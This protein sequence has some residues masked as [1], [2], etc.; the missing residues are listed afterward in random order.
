MITGAQSYL[1]TVLN[2][3]NNKNLTGSTFTIAQ[4]MAQE[5]DLLLPHPGRMEFFLLQEASIDK[6]STLTLGTNHYSVPDHL[7][8]QKVDVKVYANQLKIYS[9]GKILDTRSGL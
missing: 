2:G 5:R 9:Q 4:L 1:E 7:V 8:G 3:L 6:Y